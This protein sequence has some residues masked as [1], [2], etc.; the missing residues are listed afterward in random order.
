MMEME[1]YLE[2]IL[3][4]AWRRKRNKKEEAIL[5]WNS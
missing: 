2:L 4:A 5:L 1:A 3:L